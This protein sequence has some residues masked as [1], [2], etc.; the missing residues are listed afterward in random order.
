MAR[1]FRYG[2]AIS[3]IS[4][5]PHSEGIVDRIHE[6]NGFGASI[7]SSQNRLYC[8]EQMSLTVSTIPHNQVRRGQILV[9]PDCGV[10]MIKV[11]D[12]P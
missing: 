7:L 2:P 1:R 6:S 11:K 4:I 5:Q 9:L 3:R 10:R 12:Q 8:V